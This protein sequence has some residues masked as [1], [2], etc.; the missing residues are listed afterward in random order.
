MPIVIDET[1]QA[2]DRR[3]RNMER[4]RQERQILMESFT[5]DRKYFDRLKRRG[6]SIV[7][8]FHR[9]IQENMDYSESRMMKA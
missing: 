5:E 2:K 7:S 3:R 9:K 8:S 6:E 4:D 1:Q